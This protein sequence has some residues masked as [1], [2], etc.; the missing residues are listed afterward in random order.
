MKNVLLVFG[1]K[2]YE[3]DISVVTAAQIFNRNTLENIKLVPLYVS[4]DNRFFVY[5][6]DKMDIKDFS[7]ANF[8]S[9]AKVFKEVVFVSGEKET[10]FAKTRF[11][12]KEFLKT[13]LAVFACHGSAGE[14]GKLVSFLETYGIFSS[15]GNSLALAIC[16]N[17]FIFK[18]Q[19]KGIK[20]PV[21]KGFLIKKDLYLKD[22][23]NYKYHL[24]FLKFP[25]ILKSNN[26]G[27]SIGVFVVDK[28]EEFDT[29][30]KSAFEFDNEVLVEQFIE[31]AREFNVAV[32]GNDKE[33]IVSDIDEPLKAH[34]VLSFADKYLSDSGKIKGSKTNSMAYQQRKLPADIPTKLEDEIKFIAS[35]VF[36]LLSLQGVVRIDFLFDEQ[37]NK[38][39]VCEVNAIP[40]SLAYYFFK[41]NMVRSNDLV[42]RLVRIAESSKQNAENINDDFYP[43]ILD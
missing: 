37:K 6:P 18:K 31:N 11:G 14:N 19:M 7:L 23:E 26:G 2:S 15:A 20:V 40:G 33:F 38:V 42:D 22:I 30:L 4:R 9:N 36:S 43:N 29:A 16:M 8:K 13:D 5:K 25:V 35:K 27:S 32:I 21:V 3:H 41:E 17:K 10:L 28:K 34:E 39:Y 24:Q 12:L 1:G